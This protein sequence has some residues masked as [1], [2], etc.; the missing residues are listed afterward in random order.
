[1]LAGVA[2][3]HLSSLICA[4]AA[5]TPSVAKISWAKR[6]VRNRAN[7]KG[8][9]KTAAGIDHAVRSVA[10]CSP[11]KRTLP[12]LMRRKAGGRD[13]LSNSQMSKWSRIGALSALLVGVSLSAN[14]PFGVVA[15]SAPEGQL[16]AIWRWLDPTIRA[17]E[18]TI[19]ACRSDPACG[20]PAALRIAAI[21]DEAMKYKGRARVG[22]INGRS[23][24]PSRRRVMTLPGCPRS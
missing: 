24:R 16:S 5:V 12:R 1:M 19:A 4:F 7:P 17:D 13:R 10:D 21:I 2:A 20:S 14:E 22:H 18:A 8:G 11:C 15:V 23:T 6:I 3:L 9:G